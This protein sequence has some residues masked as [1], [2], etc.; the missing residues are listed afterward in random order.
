MRRREFLTLIGCAAA[1]WPVV[2]HAQQQI[3][4][5]VGVLCTA[6]LGLTIPPTLVARADE[7]IE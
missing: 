4:P 1:T 3:T 7:V 5:L 6:A 2:G